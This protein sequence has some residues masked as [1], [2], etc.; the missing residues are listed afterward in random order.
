[1]KELATQVKWGNGI[2]SGQTKRADGGVGYTGYGAMEEQW[3][4]MVSFGLLKV[5]RCG[6]WKHR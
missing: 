3:E 1:M 5:G 4:V 2:G 6:S